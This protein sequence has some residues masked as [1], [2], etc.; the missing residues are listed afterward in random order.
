MGTKV[1]SGRAA[2]PCS[3]RKPFDICC[4]RRP[5]QPACQD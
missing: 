5:E 3:Y 2:R 1:A 4:L